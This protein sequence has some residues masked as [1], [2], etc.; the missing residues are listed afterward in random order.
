MSK[1][2][3]AI[4]FI[5]ENHGT[6]KR[7]NSDISYYYHCFDVTKKALSY[8]VSLKDISK[9]D[10]ECSCLLHDI[11]EDTTV[12]YYDLKSK[13]SENVADLVKELTFSKETSKFLYMRSFLN[14]TDQAIVLKVADRVCN[15]FDFMQSDKRY[16]S[17]Y[18]LQAY[19]LYLAYLSRKNLLSQGI[20]ED[21]EKVQYVIRMSYNVSIFFPFDSKDLGTINANINRV[22]EI[23]YS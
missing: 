16:A 5:V 2:S 9:E 1:T 6:Q 18:A 22:E 14:K 20:L 8:N 17:K 4:Q 21:L 13:F 12:S 23:L 3:E 11:L 10:F 15:I 19:P 7:K